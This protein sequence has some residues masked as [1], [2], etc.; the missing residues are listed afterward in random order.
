MFDQRDVDGGSREQ[1][2]RQDCNEFGNL[3]HQFLPDRSLIFSLY[4]LRIAAQRNRRNKPATGKARMVAARNAQMTVCKS[5]IAVN[6]ETLSL[7]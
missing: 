1:A 2:A 5:L 3:A 4:T 7:L 6:T